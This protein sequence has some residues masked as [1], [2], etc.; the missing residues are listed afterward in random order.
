MTECYCNCHICHDCGCYI[1][2]DGIY[3]CDSCVD[4]AIEA[5]IGALT[6][7]GAVA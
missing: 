4:K 3:L 5:R 2:S 1:G 7:H 6:S